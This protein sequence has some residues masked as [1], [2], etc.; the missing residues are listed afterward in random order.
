MI[1]T[2]APKLACP[3][4]GAPLNITVAQLTCTNGHSFDIARQGYVN[5]LPVQQKRS[6][7]PGDSKEMIAARTR[8]LNT[9]IYAPIAEKLDDIVLEQF[10]A[11]LLTDQTELCLL[12]AGCGEGYYFDHLFQTLARQSVAKPISLIGLDISKPAIIAAAKRNKQI[13]WLVGSNKT[14]PVEPATVDI[15]LSLFGF[16]T[17]DSFKVSLKP[18]G[19]IILVEAGPEHLIEL[20]NIIYPTVNKSPPPNLSAAEEAGFTL[21]DSAL[22]QY[23]TG[24][25]PPEQIMNLLTMTPHLYKA[26]HEGKLAAAALDKINLTVDIVFRCLEST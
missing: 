1:T 14:P 17:F 25:I 13:T 18:H 11:S 4:D 5:L 3:L 16:P 10:S 9:G 26:T 8:F 21:T 2:K 6:K 12:D 15:I 22:L 23:K 7:H 20:R 19:K 24:D